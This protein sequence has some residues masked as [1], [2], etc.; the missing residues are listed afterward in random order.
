MSHAKAGFS[1]F[2]EHISPIVKNKNINELNVL[3][4]ANYFWFELQNPYILKK[5]KL[6]FLQKIFD[7]FYQNDCSFL[8]SCWPFFKTEFRAK[9]RNK[10]HDS[11]FVEN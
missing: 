7:G 4:I 8:L 9:F 1:N 5:H 2:L 6:V 10:S 3:K 11:N